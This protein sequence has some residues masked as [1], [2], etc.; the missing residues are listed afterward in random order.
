MHGGTCNQT[1]AI[2]HQ[3]ATCWVNESL[4]LA[5]LGWLVGGF[6]P[7]KNRTI[8]ENHHLKWK[9]DSETL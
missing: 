8:M 5:M 4:T 2:C 1:V 9:K 6:G 3:W 7:F